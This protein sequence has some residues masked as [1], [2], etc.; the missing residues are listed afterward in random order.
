MP[1]YG[2]KCFAKPTIQDDVRKCQ[3]GRNWYQGAIGCSSVALTAANII[4]CIGLKKL[5]DR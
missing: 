1:V 4:F 5:V 3:L 2:D